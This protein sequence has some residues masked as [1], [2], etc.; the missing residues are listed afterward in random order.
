MGVSIKIATHQH[1]H[2]VTQQEHYQALQNS[3]QE[4]LRSARLSFQATNMCWL[5]RLGLTLFTLPG[6]SMR[7]VTESGSSLTTPSLALNSTQ[8]RQGFT[9]PSC[10]RSVLTLTQRERCEECDVARCSWGTTGNIWGHIITNNIF[11]ISAFFVANRK[12]MIILLK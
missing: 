9:N 4:L 3:Q 11:W 6:I 5:I 12:Y 7:R 10:T 8:Q 1:V 2:H